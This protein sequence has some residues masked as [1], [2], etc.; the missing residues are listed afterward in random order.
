MCL[1]K[2]IYYLIYKVVGAQKTILK[3]KVKYPVCIAKNPDHYF[4]NLQ[5]I[6]G[7]ASMIMKGIQQNQG[8]GGA[9]PLADE[10]RGQRLCLQGLSGQQQPAPPSVI[11]VIFN[12]ACMIL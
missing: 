3:Y 1:S 8:S 6:I 10:S 12:G 11:I 5:Y 4:M 2:L 9:I 7:S